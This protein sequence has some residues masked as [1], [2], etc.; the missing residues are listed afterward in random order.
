VTAACQPRGRLAGWLAVWQSPTAGARRGGCRPRDGRH[1]EGWGRSRAAGSD[2]FSREGRHEIWG[3]K[4]ETVAWPRTG[5]GMDGNGGVGGRGS[6][7]ALGSTNSL[8]A[9]T[10]GELV[11]A[12]LHVSHCLFQD[13]EALGGAGGDGGSGGNG[14]A[15][16][17]ALGGGM[18]PVFTDW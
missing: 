3:W 6:A 10:G 5:G 18:S 4:A 16:S 15:G 7:A 13:N 11:R 8:P 14:G 2:P 9:L 17:A 1:R 12:P